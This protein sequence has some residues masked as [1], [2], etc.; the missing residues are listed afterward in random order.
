MRFF[1]PKRQPIEKINVLL[2]TDSGRFFCN[3]KASTK[4][5]SQRDKKDLVFFNR[6]GFKEFNQCFFPTADD[7]TRGKALKARPIKSIL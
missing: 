1:S 5:G 7:D 3:H 6:R 4:V 2:K